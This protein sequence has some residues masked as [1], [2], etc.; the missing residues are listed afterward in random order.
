MA[1]WAAADYCAESGFCQ[2]ASLHNLR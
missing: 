1:V 2:E